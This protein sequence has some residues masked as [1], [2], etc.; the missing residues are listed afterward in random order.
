M[1]YYLIGCPLGHSFSPEIHAAL[2]IKDYRLRELSPE[3]MPGFLKQGH[4]E[5]LNVTIP[6]KGAVI[7][8]LTEMSETARQI[9]AVNTIVR[10][11]DGGLYGDNTD[12]AGFRKLARETGVD[13][14][15]KRV[16]IL[17]TGGTSRTVSYVARTEGAAVVRHVSRGGPIDYENVYVLVNTTPG[18]MY[19]DCFSSR[20]DLTRFPELTGVLDVVYNPLMTPLVRQAKALGLP[21]ANGLLMLVEQ[22]RAAQELFLGRQ[23]PEQVMRRAFSGLLASRSNLILIGMPGSGKTTIGRLT[24][25]L[26]QRQFLDADAALV[27]KTGME[28]PEIFER[29]GEEGFREREEETVAELCA[30]GGRVIAMGGGAV[31]RE[32]NRHAMRMNG[33]VYLIDRPLQQLDRA[34]R[35]LSSSTQVLEKMKETRMPYYLETADVQMDNVAEPGDVAMKIAEEFHEYFGD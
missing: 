16:L 18:G 26:M 13:F 9:G 30:K 19:P 25:E 11:A 32:R 20:I 35:P 24:A 34:G 23:I 4:F 29:Y 5:G 8:Y 28:I 33:R 31:L 21:A 15:G 17:G 3:D 22:A 2:G 7:P 6:Y 14:Q 27:E 10:T 12:A 1:S